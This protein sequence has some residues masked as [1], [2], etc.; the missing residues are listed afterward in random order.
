MN[1]QLELDEIIKRNSRDNL[2]PRLLLHSCCAPCSSY[3]L[4]CLANYFEITVFFYNPNIYPESEY[5]KRADELVNFIH[6][7]NTKG[8]HKVEEY[9][10]ENNLKSKTDNWNQGDNL[11]AGHNFRFSSKIDFLEGAYDKTVFYQLTAGMEDEKE[12]GCRCLLC[13]RLRLEETAKKAKLEG[14]DYFATTLTVSPMK[15]AIKLNEIG[16]ELEENHGIN[17]LPSDFKKRNGYKRSL[18][19]STEYNL[20]RQNYCGCEFSM[21]SKL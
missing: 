15:S 16:R 1:Y 19:L 21:P 9:F 17:W 5:R 11:N 14:Y 4:E 2:L 8:N 13:Y 12:G 20:Y 6:N 3:V 18:E 10:K 7:I